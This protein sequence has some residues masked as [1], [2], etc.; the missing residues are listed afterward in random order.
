M[1]EITTREST[2]I[3]VLGNLAQEAQF[4]ARSIANGMIQ[5]GR[6]L[7][8]AKPLVKHGE[9]ERW[10]AENAGCSVRYAQMFMQAYERFGDNPAVMQIKERGKIFKLLALPSGTEEQFLADNNVAELSTREVEDAVRKVREEMGIE[11]AK[12]RKARK[13][14]EERAEELELKEGTVPQEAIDALIA[15]ENTITEQQRELTR[16]ANDGRAALQ[17]AQRLRRENASLTREIEEQNQLIEE[18]QEQYDKVRG[19]LLALQS[20]AAKGDA[21]RVPA[22]EL[23]INVFASAVRQFI[24]TCARM[25][26]MGSTFGTMLLSEKNAYD[27]LLRTI[28]GWAQ[29]ARKAMNTIA[30][31]E[32]EI[33]G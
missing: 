14:A 8:E 3:A 27:E 12:E 33:H 18:A 13:L 19:D 10:I 29:S 24:G 20:A 22:D 6:V 28:E 1:N 16:I 25:P 15:K 32:V 23:T 17:E 26:H 7:T 2:E 9:W 4:Y 30:Y 11:L 21:E 5:L 31:E